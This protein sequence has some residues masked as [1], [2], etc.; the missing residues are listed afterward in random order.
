MIL[1]RH[2]W[3]DP[4]WGGFVSFAPAPF[5]APGLFAIPLLMMV[6]GIAMILGK[7]DE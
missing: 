1:T 4:L 6:L 7:S 5:L 3:I 2:D